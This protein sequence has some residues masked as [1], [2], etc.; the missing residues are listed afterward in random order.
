MHKLYVDFQNYEQTYEFEK[1]GNLAKIYSYCSMYT[2]FRVFV[3]TSLNQDYD[4]TFDTLKFFSYVYHY[5]DTK[6]M[7][8][9]GIQQS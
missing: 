5:W 7:D 4:I 9:N 1:D 6:Y 2:L 3:Y 8:P